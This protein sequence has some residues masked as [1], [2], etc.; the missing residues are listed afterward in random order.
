V[1]ARRHAWESSDEEA[2]GAARAAAA[3]PWESEEEDDDDEEEEEVESED[4]GGA[5]CPSLCGSSSDGSEPDEDPATPGERLIEENVHL[6]LA[7]NITARD[8]CTSMY[9]AHEA[10]VAECKQYAY[11]P[12][13]VDHRHYSR[14]LQKRLPVFASRHLLYQLE[15]AC[16]GSDLGRASRP[17]PVVPAQEAVFF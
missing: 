16:R 5:G 11:Q 15:V 14:F 9:W 3:H 7:R 13:G 2:E 10:G 12:S 17:L 6:L 8:F 4:E 1:R